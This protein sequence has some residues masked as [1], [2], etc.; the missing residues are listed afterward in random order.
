MAAV[1]ATGSLS[2]PDAYVLAG[3]QKVKNKV[4]RALWLTLV[5]L[6]TW[7]A[8]IGRIAVEASPDK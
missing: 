2:P 5:I 8:E 4:N 3:K 1:N 6:A 7:E